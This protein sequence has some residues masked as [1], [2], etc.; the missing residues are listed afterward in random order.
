MNEYH[1]GYAAVVGLV[2]LAAGCLLY[3]LGGRNNKALRRFVA[4]FILSATVWGNALYMGTFGWLMLLLYPVKILEFVQG[5]SADHGMPAP[6]KRLL[7]V[8]TSLAGGVLCAYSIGGVAWFVL[9]LHA[10]VGIGTVMFAVKNPFAAAAEE[11]L[12]CAMNNLVLM[13]YPFVIVIGG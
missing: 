7:V 5:Y 2:G 11:P 10:L 6:L 9:I 3:M 12:V 13:F 4:S 8:L 1:I